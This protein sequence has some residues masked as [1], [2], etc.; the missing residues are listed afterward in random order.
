MSEL[1]VGRPIGLE[2]EPVRLRVRL[3]ELLEG[4]LRLDILTAYHDEATFH[5][6]RSVL[7]E[8]LSSAA[9]VRLLLGGNA[10]LR[11]GHG[12]S[13]LALLDEHAARTR[14]RILRPAGGLLH[15]K[16]YLVRGPGEAAHMVLGSSNFTRGGLTKNIELNVHLDGTTDTARQSITQATTY[17]D[18]LWQH[19]TPADIAYW[20]SVESLPAPDPA[21]VVDLANSG[22]PAPILLGRP[23]TARGEQQ[24]DEDQV[25]SGDFTFAIQL[26]PTE[27]DRAP[28]SESPGTA[29][30]YL[31]TRQPALVALFGAR[32]AGRPA[33][34]KTRRPGEDSE[35]RNFEV[36]VVAHGLR[37]MRGQSTRSRAT[38]QTRWRGDT[39]PKPLTELRF[40]WSVE[41]RAF[42]AED[43]GR[44][45]TVGD[46]LIFRWAVDEGVLIS[47]LD[48]YMVTGDDTVLARAL[49]R[50]TPRSDRR[51][52]Y[53]F[54]PESAWPETEAI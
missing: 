45:P 11:P 25:D 1:L 31:S 40:D 50:G 36:P 35:T 12:T 22:L 14:I 39:E 6:A 47:P 41:T 20:R 8:L 30:V 51:L 24:P 34:Q 13:A 15:P 44:T 27:V 2:G 5:Y 26:S 46:V 29:T 16:I 48:L 43:F 42:F 9:E 19:G 54:L 7:D 4:A 37:S 38:L 21:P 53:A 33:A 3:R 28:W 23:A 32:R 10:P 49:E 18:H 52:R 17:F